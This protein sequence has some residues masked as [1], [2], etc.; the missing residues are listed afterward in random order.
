VR[1]GVTRAMSMARVVMKNGQK[2]QERP[3]TS[4]RP[5][6]SRPRLNFTERTGSAT[7]RYATLCTDGEQEE[8]VR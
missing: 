3:K 2:R 1:A 6:I 5:R 4:A 7:R 8:A